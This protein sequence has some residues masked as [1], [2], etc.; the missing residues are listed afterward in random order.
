MNGES[1][2]YAPRWIKALLFSVLLFGVALGATL[3][4]G[5]AHYNRPDD[6]DWVLVAVSLVQFSLSGLAIGAALFYSDKTASTD[7]LRR[8]SKTF[9]DKLLPDAIALVRFPA[10]QGGLNLENRLIVIAAVKNESSERFLRIS[11][12]TRGDQAAFTVY[13]LLNVKRILVCIYLDAQQTGIAGI[14]SREQIARLLEY[15]LQAPKAIGYEAQIKFGY[16]SFAGREV[17]CVTYH[18][19]ELDY[20]FLQNPSKML[21]YATDV[22]M[23]LRSFA[24]RQQLGLNLV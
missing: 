15:E 18:N 4:Y 13:V 1:I 5:Y 11:D 23:M 6:A 7:L 17:Y 2:V 19:E 22:A 24:V 10:P 8:R 14:C 9:L 20:D 16:E 21:F 12:A 3:I